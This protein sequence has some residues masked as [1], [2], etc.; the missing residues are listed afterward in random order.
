MSIEDL[1]AKAA[2]AANGPESKPVGKGNGG[3]VTEAE[4]VIEAEE[5]EADNPVLID[6]ASQDEMLNWM[7][8]YSGYWN[9]LLPEHHGLEAFELAAMNA[10]INSGKL[11]EAIVAKP[12]SFVYAMSM[13]AHFGLMPDGLQ[14]ALVPYNGAVKFIPMYRGY[15]T[16][17]HRTGMIRSVHFDHICEG[18]K[19]V[20]NKGALPPDDFKHE[21][22][23]FRIDE[24]EREPRVAYAFAWMTSGFRTEVALMG[25]KRAEFIRDNH[26]KSYIAAE[27]ARIRDSE[28]AS[29]PYLDKFHSPW[30]DHFDAMWL[31]SVVILLA[32]RMDLSPEL[33]ELLAADV[34]DLN[35]GQKVVIPP[36]VMRAITNS[37]QP[38]LEAAKNELEKASEK[39]REAALIQA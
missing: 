21:I 30:H 16:L 38:E 19:V 29:K 33:R 7:R 1:K 13:C 36:K 9:P 5:V 3:K 14:A 12:M 10:I 39:K 31:K 8:R 37:N 26:S 22:D 17:M 15:I 24:E 28:Y 25:R 11:R 2:E 32:K 23:V 34:A 18:D 27:K 4:E 20:L 35:T 6:H